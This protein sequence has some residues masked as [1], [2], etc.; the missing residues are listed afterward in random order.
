MNGPPP[1]SSNTTNLYNQTVI[2]IDPEIKISPKISIDVIFKVIDR[3]YIFNPKNYYQD[4]K[5]RIIYVLNNSI[6]LKLNVN[7]LQIDFKILNYIMSLAQLL[8]FD[9]IRSSQFEAIISAVVG[10]LNM[11]MTYKYKFKRFLFQR[12]LNGLIVEE[13][14]MVLTSE[15]FERTHSSSITG[16]GLG[17]KFAS[18]RGIS[19]EN[20]GDLGRSV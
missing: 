19:S 5:H 10:A 18:E 12:K 9:L 7:V 6:K 15:E 4:S 1:I 17:F 14:N 20:L 11:K 2:D 13:V 16:V 3:K 8:T